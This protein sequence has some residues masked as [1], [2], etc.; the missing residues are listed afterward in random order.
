MTHIQADATQNQKLLIVH[1][2]TPWTSTSSAAAPPCMREFAAAASDLFLGYVCEFVR[3]DSFICVK[4]TCN[5][6]LL[7]MH[8]FVAAALDFIVGYMCELVSRDSFIYSVLVRRDSFIFNVFPS[9]HVRVCGG[10]VG[11]L[12]WVC[13]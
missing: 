4:I 9:V 10:C 1:F 3:R 12:S 6:F 8:K 7:C 13:V 5:V 11:L 2:H